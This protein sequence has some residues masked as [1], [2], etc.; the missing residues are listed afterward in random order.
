M[1]DQP[2]KP[3]VQAT[4]AVA[5][6]SILPLLASSLPS[7]YDHY[8]M[9]ACVFLAAA[10]MLATQIPAPKDDKSKWWF[11]YTILQILAA[12]RDKAINAAVYLKGRK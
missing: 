2:Q 11:A 4:K 1:T 8:L 10:G 5:V 12:N 9:W 6:G 3:A 7:P